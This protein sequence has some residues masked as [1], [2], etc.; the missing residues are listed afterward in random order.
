MKLR[1]KILIFG[2]F[3]A[4][5]FAAFDLVNYKS[6]KRKKRSGKKANVVKV[7]ISAVKAKLQGH[8]L[9]SKQKALLK[10][11]ARQIDK[12]PI[13]DGLTP[14]EL[15]KERKRLE[16]ERLKKLG[17]TA[18]RGGRKKQKDEPSMFVYSGFFNNENKM[19]AIINNFDLSA[20][21]ELGSSGYVVKDITEAQ[22]VLKH[23]VNGKSLVV[24]FSQQQNGEVKYE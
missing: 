24:K 4:L 22:V 11:A 6:R 2:M 23:R 21:D 12:N 14:S 17:Q 16:K 5:C 7:D 20:G 9:T 8:A 18:S 3:G 13:L 15:E 19:V 10:I 1:E